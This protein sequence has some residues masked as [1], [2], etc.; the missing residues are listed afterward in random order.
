MNLDD[1]GASSWHFVRREM[2]RETGILF[3]FAL[4]FASS[5][6]VAELCRALTLWSIAGGDSICTAR[7]LRV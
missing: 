5:A 4:N 1:F 6:R 2:W 7:S 3:V